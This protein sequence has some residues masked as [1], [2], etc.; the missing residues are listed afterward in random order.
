MSH[1]RDYDLNN[2]KT[3]ANSIPKINKSAI[4]TWGFA[5]IVKSLQLKLC[6][7]L[8]KKR[9]K[10]FPRPHEQGHHKHCET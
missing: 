9:Q 10:P 1:S 8:Y 7:R 4:V 3:I 5:A 2:K 6:H